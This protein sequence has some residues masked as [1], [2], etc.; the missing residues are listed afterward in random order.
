MTLASVLC[1]TDFRWLLPTLS[2]HESL[3]VHD[4]TVCEQAAPRSYLL[5]SRITKTVSDAVVYTC[6]FAA[7]VA[8]SS[9]CG[10]LCYTQQ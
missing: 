8:A 2:V 4:A 1:H 7:T 9:C 3:A 6:L 5:H 10:I